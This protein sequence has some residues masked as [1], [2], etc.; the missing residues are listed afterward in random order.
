MDLIQTDIDYVKKILPNHYTV[1]E[2]KSKGSIHCQSSIG[3]RKEVD[4][5]DEEHWEYIFQA[6]K[7]YFNNR[8]SEIFCN[9]CFCYSDF[10]I[11]LKT[12]N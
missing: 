6:F 9:V 2:S 11:Y 5:E 8:F 7:K 1:T 4:S 12:K 10:T 3:I